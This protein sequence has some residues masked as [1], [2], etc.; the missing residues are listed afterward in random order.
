MSSTLWL[1]I[2]IGELIILLAIIVWLGNYI[3]KRSVDYYTLFIIGI[4]LLLFG[5]FIET[6]LLWLPGLIVMTL[7]IAHR[8]EWKKNRLHWSDLTEEEKIFKCRV[9]ISLFVVVVVSDVVLKGIT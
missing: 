5:F 4:I 6:I 2:A 1:I 8:G 9:A 7:A 3:K